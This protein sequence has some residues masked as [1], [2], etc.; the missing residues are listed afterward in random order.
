MFLGCGF[1]VLHAHGGE[2]AEKLRLQFV[3]IHQHELWTAARSPP[4]FGITYPVHLFLSHFP[5]H[6]YLPRHQV[7]EEAGEK[8]VQCRQPRLFGSDFGIDGGE[9][10]DDFL[11]F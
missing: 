7:M 3:A 5:L 2:I 1:D 4:N 9:D 8:I 10:M 6:P 11:L